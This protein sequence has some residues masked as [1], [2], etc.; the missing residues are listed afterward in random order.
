MTSKNYFLKVIAFILLSVFNSSAVLCQNSDSLQQ[1]PKLT[2]LNHKKIMTQLLG[3]PKVEIKTIGILVFDGFDA[4]ET[5]APMVVLSELM[6]VQ[7]EYI[8]VKQ[9]GLVKG[10]LMEVEVKKTISDIKKLDLLVIPGAKENVMQTMLN[11]K[12][13]LD[14]LK[15]IDNTTKI[16]TASGYGVLFLAKTGILNGKKAATVNLKGKENLALYGAQY[17]SSRYVKDG[18]YY[19]SEKSTACIDQM[20]FLI[21]EVY[22]DNY[23][24][25]AMLDLEYNPI[26]DN[27]NSGFDVSNQQTITTSEGFQLAKSTIKSTPIDTVGIL[28]Y[29]GAFTLDFLGPL[30]V[31][32]SVDEMHVELIG[33]KKGLVKSGRTVFNAKHSIADIDKLDI[34]IIPGG[35]IGTLNM[36]QDTILRKWI[37]EIDKNSKYTASVCTGAWILGEAGL[38]RNKNATSHWYMKKEVLTHYQAKPEDKRFV[39]DA[40]YWTSAGVSAGIDFCF[41]LL[42]ELYGTTTT[43]EAFSRLAYFPEPIIKGGIPENTNPLVVDMMNQMYNYMML[44][45]LRKNGI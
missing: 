2:L 17:D 37:L 13:F 6:N 20:L 22:G 38:L 7:I 35:S 19:T 44:K 4:M 40:K 21:H 18:K 43:S 29:D 8:G 42:N 26:L 41:A 32:S 15:K 11:D 16:T 33:Y 30:C 45:R 25:A 31:L 12:V 3:K 9:K 28:V 36:S 10:D 5:I 34:L 14:W 1:L 24:Q 23:T 27:L 39:K